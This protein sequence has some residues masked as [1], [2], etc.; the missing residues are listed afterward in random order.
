[1]SS[2]LSD[3]FQSLS[4]QGEP[5]ELVINLQPVFPMQEAPSCRRCGCKPKYR[6][7]VSPHNPN[8]N[9]GRPYYICIKCKTDRKCKVSKIDHQ[10]GWISWDD[11]RGV[12]LSNQNCGCGV[13]CRQDRAGEHSSCPGRGF[14]TCAT[15]SCGYFSF[16]TDGRTDDE[17]KDAEEAPDAGFEPW[18]F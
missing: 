18:L 7:T 15:G 16:R 2:E 3:C 1:M 8:G 6:N 10:K 17:A 11:D 14:W 12:D 5:V 4:I 9:A 13:V